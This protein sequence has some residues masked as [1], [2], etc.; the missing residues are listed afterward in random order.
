MA[1]KTSL[2]S[3]LCN[4]QLKFNDFDVYTQVLGDKEHVKTINII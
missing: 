2:W 1:A 4:Y 3:K